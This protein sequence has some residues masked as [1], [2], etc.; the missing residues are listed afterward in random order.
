MTSAPLFIQD[1]DGLWHPDAYAQGPFEGL[2][3]G[4][5]AG[6]MC[7]AVED[8]AREQGLGDIASVTTHFLKPVLR[9][10]LSVTVTPLRLGRRV[11]VIDAALSMEGLVVAVQRVTLIAPVANTNLPEPLRVPVD[12]AQL[13]ERPPHRTKAEGWMW[14]AMDARIGA[15][16]LS[17]FRLNRPLLETPS[18][19]AF[20]L[21]AADW[22]HGLGPPL[23]AEI[24]PMI[25]S[26]NTDL[27]VN[28]L[29]APQGEWVGV[30]WETA[31]SK[32]SI[33]AGWAALHDTQGLFGRV[34]MSVALMAAA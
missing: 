11:S 5:V 27:A 24:R 6:L 1:S 8:M 10:P 20:A 32:Y 2:Q 13:P 33:G 3:G 19:F 23:G 30:E 31:W 34:A 26:P 28:F 22:A 21:P 25:A 17:W 4:G 16:Q 29:R 14:M 7:A 9:K 15:G 12:P 18:R